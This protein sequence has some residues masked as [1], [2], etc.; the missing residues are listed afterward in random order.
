[1][2][3]NGHSFRSTAASPWSP[4]ARAA[5]AS[6]LPWRWRRPAR[7]TA[8][9]YANDHRNAEAAFAELDAR[10]ATNRASCTA[11]SPM[12]SRSSRMCR[13]VADSLGPIDILVV[14]ATCSQPELPFEEYDWEFFQPM[15]DFFVKSPVL[16]M[17]AMPAAHEAAA[18]GPHHSHHQRSRRAR[19]RRRSAPTSPPKAARPA[20]R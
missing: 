4:A 19:R 2:L 16:L 3:N 12:P 6:R 11:T 14:N 18:V 7:A 20:W 9:N 5:W 15:L 8:M 10:V 17:K 1:M 13:E